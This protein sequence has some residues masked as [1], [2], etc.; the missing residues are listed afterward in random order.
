M[1]LNKHQYKYF[2]LMFTIMLNDDKKEQYDHSSDVSD[3][4]SNNGDIE[5]GNS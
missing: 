2:L 3:I 4:S 1:N 5:E